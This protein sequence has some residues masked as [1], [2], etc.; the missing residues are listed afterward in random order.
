MSFALNR[1][2]VLSDH[3]PISRSFTLYQHFS[4][5]ITPRITP[6]FTRSSIESWGV[7]FTRQGTF[8]LLEAV[9]SSAP[10]AE[11]YRAGATA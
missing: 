1:H 9:C 6:H 2:R 4:N 3:V 10:C 11:L 5:D 8:G 7:P